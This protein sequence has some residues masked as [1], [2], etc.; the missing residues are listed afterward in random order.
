MVRFLRA[1]LFGAV[2][3]LSIFEAGADPGNGGA[4][5]P[6]ACVAIRTA[7]DLNKIRNNLAGDF[8]LA[9][10]IDLASVANF[11]PIGTE[12]SL[13][14]FTGTLD[15]RGHVI[16][17]LKIRTDWVAGLFGAIGGLQSGTTVK[18]LGLVNVRVVSTGGRTTDDVGALASAQYDGIISNV[19]VTGSVE[20]VE[21]AEV[22]GLIGVQTGGT[23]MRSHSGAAVTGRNFGSIVGG[24]VGSQ[25]RGA[26]IVESYA[27]G[28]VAAY[29][30]E[31]VA[32]GLVGSVGIF[33]GGS[34][35]RSFAS[36]PVT[37]GSPWNRVGA[38]TGEHNNIR[39]SYATGPVAVS[40]PASAVYESYAAG[41]GAILHGP[42]ARQTYA[43][44]RISTNR[45]SFTFRG[46][47]VADDCDC[48]H[49]TVASSYWN[50]ETT[51]ASTSASGRPRTTRQLQS[52]LP[53]GFDR[54]VWGITP[55]VTFPYLK[56]PGLTF[57]SPLAIT[58]LGTRIY[59]FVPISQR[60]PSEYSDPVAHERAA[61]LAAV[62]TILARAIGVAKNVAALKNVAIDTYFWND[63]TLTA[64]FAGP[65]TNHA[66]LGSVRAI[67]AAT[68]LGAAN[69]IGPLRNDRVVILRAAAAGKTYW[70]LATS[71]ITDAS[72]NVTRVIANDAWTGRQVRINPQT[73]KVVEPS[74]LALPSI[75]V[76]GYRI[77]TL[78]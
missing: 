62:Y 59:T 18:N 78:R 74:G 26:K 41:L 31:I 58:V 44:G 23:I 37:A 77:V 20:G 42:G 65:V 2:S 47:L 55:N 57:Q 61:G 66:T 21:T 33:G 17:N 39:F 8:C 53:P 19:F 52:A 25:D 69:V 4:L 64:S 71:F 46:G 73:K 16:R 5:D 36:G 6:K 63:A 56:A 35:V 76:N 3:T 48:P 22:G 14:P 30:F 50:T 51:G 12:T 34:I 1:C 68:P 70:L 75:T 67:P 54:S 29:G 24:L 15:G 49:V 11:K 7:A 27:T 38:L 32:G 9:A 13:N 45:P 72:G 40:I 10:D 60:E 28:P 43:V